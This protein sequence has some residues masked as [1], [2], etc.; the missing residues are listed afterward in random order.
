MTQVDARCTQC[1]HSNHG[2]VS[3]NQNYVTYTVPR[4][5]LKHGSGREHGTEVLDCPQCGEETVHN[6]CKSSVP[7]A[8]R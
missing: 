6:R 5:E 7:S 2:S 8:K 4:D 3:D 1:Q